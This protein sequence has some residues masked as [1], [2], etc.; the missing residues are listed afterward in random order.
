MMIVF[1]LQKL[2]PTFTGIKPPYTRNNRHITPIAKV[3]SDKD[4]EDAVK[5]AEETSDAMEGYNGY[6]FWLGEDLVVKKYKGENAFSNDPSREIKMLDALFDNGLIFQNSQLGMYAF[7]DGDSTYLVSTKVDGKEPDS[8][9]SPFTKENLTSLV[10][11]ILQMDKG[12]NMKDSSKGGYNDRIRFMNYDFNGGNIKLTENKAGL[13]DFEYSVLENIDD[14]IE[15]TIIRKDTGANC[16]QSDTSALP[17]SLRSFEFYT[18]CPYLNGAEGDISELFNDYLAI[19]GSYHRKMYRFFG[20]FAQESAFPDIAREISIHELAHA[21]LLRKNADGKVP[22]DIV[23]SEARKIQMSH[24]MHEQ[25]QFSD[26]GRIN[27]KQLKKY[28]EDSI[29]FFKTGLEKALQ[30]GDIN[31]EVYYRDCLELFSSWKRV[32]DTLKVK[33]DKKDPEIMRKLTDDYAKTLDS[34]VLAE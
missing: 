28:T 32:N 2:S 8:V 30:N 7:T 19:K 27:P 1:N 18:F 9:K 3:P 10:G 12:M 14:M 17:S 15:K 5:A 21:N 33:I 31:R 29:R 23:L 26:T 24:F 11:I 13:F 25:S 22:T 34:T 16:H 4:I 6:A 20:D